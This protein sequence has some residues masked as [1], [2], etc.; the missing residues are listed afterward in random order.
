MAVEGT[1]IPAPS[2]VCFFPIY[3]YRHLDYKSCALLNQI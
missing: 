3:V 1:V 2:C